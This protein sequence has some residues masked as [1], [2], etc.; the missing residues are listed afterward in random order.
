VVRKEA[1]GCKKD[2]DYLCLS[3][4]K[5]RHPHKADVFRMIKL[6]KASDSEKSS[7]VGEAAARLVI[8]GS[9][10]QVSANTVLLQK[11]MNV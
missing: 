3:P 10:D 8:R 7:E 6:G 4:P 5:P 9:G 11:R 2:D 1:D